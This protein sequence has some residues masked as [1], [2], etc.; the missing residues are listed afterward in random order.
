MQIK[1]RWRMVLE[2]DIILY[3]NV[4]YHNGSCYILNEKVVCSIL[5]QAVSNTERIVYRMME[6]CFKSNVQNMHIAFNKN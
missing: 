5:E 6:K 3:R 1:T 2:S 4:G